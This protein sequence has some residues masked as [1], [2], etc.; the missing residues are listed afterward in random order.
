MRLNKRSVYLL[1]AVGSVGL[2][3]AVLLCLTGGPE[4]RP[5]ETNDQSGDYRVGTIISSDSEY[6][7]AV[8]NEIQEK[9]L[10]F[11]DSRGIS[12][13]L[14]SR[15]VNTPLIEIHCFMRD[16]DGTI[17]PCRV[18]SLYMVSSD[19][20][21]GDYGVRG[22]GFRTEL[23]LDYGEIARLL[24]GKRYSVVAGY[25]PNN[26]PGVVYAKESETFFETPASLGPGEIYKVELV[27][28]DRIKE[29]KK[30]EEKMALK[31]RAREETLNLKLSDPPQYPFKGA[32]VV[33][34]YDGKTKQRFDRK[35]ENCFMLAGPMDLGGEV[36]AYYSNGVENRTWVYL[37]KLEK[38][39]IDLPSD[40][41]TLIAPENLVEVGIEVQK[42]NREDLLRELQ[43]IAFYTDQNAKLPIF[44]APLQQGGDKRDA[45]R[46]DAGLVKLHVLPGSYFVRFVEADPSEREIPVGEMKITGQSQRFYTLTVP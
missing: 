34:Y 12:N 35:P 6:N 10:S 31:E 41:Q 1:G 14:S 21:G 16:L 22:V 46:K 25:E 23:G 27:V 36:L 28:V 24:Y 15:D 8:R 11:V 38:R 2:T 44:W 13:C 39:Q 19:G 40:A 45:G 33:L 37:R 26:G 32:W 9:G 42:G 43:A 5:T 29:R 4:D 17:R 7:R 3:V 20:R 18:R 30:L